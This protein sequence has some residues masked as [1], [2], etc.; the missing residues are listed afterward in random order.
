M[1]V[2][3]GS[4]NCSAAGSSQSRSGNSDE[5]PWPREWELGLAMS[6]GHVVAPRFPLATGVDGEFEA[7]TSGSDG[8]T[9]DGGMG[10]SRTIGAF[11]RLTLF[12]SILRRRSSR[13][14]KGYIA[15]VPRKC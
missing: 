3:G 13:H 2:D 8:S 7:L 14:H 4:G 6:R 5:C 12:L 11:S 9:T 10:R 1:V 15:S